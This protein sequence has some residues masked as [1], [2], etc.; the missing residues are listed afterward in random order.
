MLHTGV[1]TFVSNFVIVLL[2]I[3]FDYHNIISPDLCSIPG[4]NDCDNKTADCIDVTG[5]F[6]CKCK[7]GYIK[8][9]FTD[10]ECKGTL[11]YHYN[12]HS[13]IISLQTQID[14]DYVF[15]IYLMLWRSPFQFHVIMVIRKDLI[16]N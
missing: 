9:G 15:K 5:G 6:E 2:Q 12:I 1:E 13:T 10:K 11:F 8:E 7:A 16:F 4:L 14:I 3:S